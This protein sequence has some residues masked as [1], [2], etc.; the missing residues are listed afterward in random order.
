MV[1]SKQ[2]IIC[3][4]EFFSGLWKSIKSLT[5]QLFHKKKRTT[6]GIYKVKQVEQIF[7]TVR[8]CQRNTLGVGSRNMTRK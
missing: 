4:Q 2:Q 3:T 6:E 7:E 8:E 5:E 1:C